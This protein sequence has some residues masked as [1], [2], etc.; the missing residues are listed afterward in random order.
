[1]IQFMDIIILKM[2]VDIGI[3]LNSISWGSIF[4]ALIGAFIGGGATL[5]G[6]FFSH[7]N[8]KKIEQDKE[9]KF[10][11]SVVLAIGAELKTL[12]DLYEK[13][14]DEKFFNAN[15]TPYLTISYIATQDFTSIYS[16]NTQNLGKIKDNVLCSKIIKTYA[17]IK[18]FLEASSLYK[19]LLKDFNSRQV[20]FLCNTFPTVY[21]KEEMFIFNVREELQAIKEKAKAGD[22]QWLNG[23][24]ISKEQAS[25]FLFCDD[26]LIGRLTKDSQNIINKYIEI[27]T[28]I[29][30]I[31]LELEHNYNK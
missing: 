25:Y 14:M 20:D 4:P 24:P 6:V 12:K 30:E 2:L 16:G 26:S 28:G 3:T 8:N 15:Q 19:T 31:L 21:K 23:S 18:Q 17:N 5:L 13:E 22:W 7:E 9:N 27:K 29:N 10:E 1:M 11:K